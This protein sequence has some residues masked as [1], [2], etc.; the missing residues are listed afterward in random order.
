MVVV[1]VVVLVLSAQ[2]L[3]LDQAEVLVVMVVLEQ[4]LQLMQLQ[5]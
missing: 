4:Q 1:A 2:V 3:H 5:Q